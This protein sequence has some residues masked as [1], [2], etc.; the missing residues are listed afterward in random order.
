MAC[1][2]DLPACLGLATLITGRMTDYFFGGSCYLFQNGQN[3]QKNTRVRVF[4][5]LPMAV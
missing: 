1:Q 3:E 5:L 2:H 4:Y